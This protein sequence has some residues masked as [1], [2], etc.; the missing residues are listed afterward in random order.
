M[1]GKRGGEM[2]Y[3]AIAIVVLVG[4]TQ[5]APVVNVFVQQPQG[6]QGGSAATTG[7][8]GGQAGSG[9]QL[10]GAGGQGGVGGAG[11]EGGHYCVTDHMSICMLLCSIYNPPGWAWCEGH[12]VCDPGW[13][14]PEGSPTQPGCLYVGDHPDHPECVDV[15]CCRSDD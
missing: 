8:V 14:G 2:R 3:L 12:A 7:G 6:G 9:G 13:C 5:P 1:L 11:G 4:C 15:W 10:G